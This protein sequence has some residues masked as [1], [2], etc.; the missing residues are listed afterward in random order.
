MT[1]LRA[2]VK[3]FLLSRAFLVRRADVRQHRARRPFSPFS[4]VGGRAR[5]RIP[6]LGCFLYYKLFVVIDRHPWGR[7]RVRLRS[8]LEA[9][10]LETSTP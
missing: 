6:L 2:V 1:T 9:H 10:F 3:R 5:S 8:E 7:P 4:H